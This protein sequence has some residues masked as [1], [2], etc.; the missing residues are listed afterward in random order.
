MV[1]GDRRLVAASRSHTRRPLS[2]ASDDID[3]DD[4]DSE[5]P[6]VSRE[7]VR[8]SQWDGRAWPTQ[9]QACACACGTIVA[10]ISGAGL[11]SH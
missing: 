1:I 2:A 6:I 7:F 11:T 5:I 8:I 10:F 9:C 3:R 4:I